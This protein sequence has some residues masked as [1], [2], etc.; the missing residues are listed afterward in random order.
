MD[1]YILNN[2]YILY[3]NI[4]KQFENNYNKIENILLYKQYN[5]TRIKHDIGINYYETYN[6]YIINKKSK[7]LNIILNDI[8]RQKYEINNII[9]DYYKKIIIYDNNI[10]NKI[11]NNNENELLNIKDY[12]I[13]YNHIYSIKNDKRIIITEKPD[14]TYRIIYQS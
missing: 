11:I 10:I 1:K 2:K 7:S 6:E 3:K 12:I 4:I 5:N 14:N 8:D 13:S 9:K